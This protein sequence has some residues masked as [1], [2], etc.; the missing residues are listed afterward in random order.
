M[1]EPR[2]RKFKH[3]ERHFQPSKTRSG[4]RD[5]TKSGVALAHAQE[6]TK[7]LIYIWSA[8]FLRAR[9]G[10]AR[11][12]KRNI[13]RKKTAA[14]VLPSALLSGFV[15]LCFVGSATQVWSLRARLSR[16]AAK[17]CLRYASQVLQIPI[18]TPEP[19]TIIVVALK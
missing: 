16:L 19:S 7:E 6:C 9:N 12:Q 15:F 13:L 8:I 4:T 2:N 3:L 10:R 14:D 5:D 11:A 17:P 1:E 18:P